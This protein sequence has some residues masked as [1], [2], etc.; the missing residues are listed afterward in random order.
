MLLDEILDYQGDRA[1]LQAGDPSNVR[2]RQRLVDAN[3]VEDEVAIDLPR[4][5]VGRALAA[6]EVESLG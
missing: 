1:P 5:R 4:R 3:E 2:A 6:S